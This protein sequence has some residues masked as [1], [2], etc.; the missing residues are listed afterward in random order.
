M[1]D[2]F[3]V[4]KNGAQSA[5]LLSLRISHVFLVCHFLPPQPPVSSA[6]VNIDTVLWYRYNNSGIEVNKFEKCAQATITPDAILYILTVFRMVRRSTR[7]T[8]LILCFTLNYFESYVRRLLFSPGQC[9]THDP[10]LKARS[11]YYYSM[12]RQLGFQGLVNSSL[13]SLS[14]IVV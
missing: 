12:N 3:D 6:P 4:N 14:C 1:S 2:A 11:S 9:H 13:N 10:P 8:K 7:Y 5:P